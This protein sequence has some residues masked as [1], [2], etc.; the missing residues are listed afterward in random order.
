MVTDPAGKL[1]S[2]ADVT[3]VNDA[4]NVNYAAEVNGAGIYATSVLPPGHYHIQ[5][6]KRGFKTLIKAD[7]ILNCRVRL[8]STS[9]CPSARPQRASQS[10]QTD[11]RSTRPMP[12]SAP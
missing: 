1:V 4:T 7:I 2:G 8:H 6:S 9:L 3:I 11:Y 12:A 10:K 5:V